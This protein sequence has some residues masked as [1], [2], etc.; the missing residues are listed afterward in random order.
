M[1]LSFLYLL[2]ATNLIVGQVPPIANDDIATTIQNTPLNSSAPGLLENDTHGAGDVIIIT[3]FLINGTTLLPD[4]LL[5]L[6]KEIL[7]FLKM[8]AIL[9]LPLEIIL[10]KFL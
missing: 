4:K 3:E 10:G 9:L 5:I 7:Q 6:L 1:P 8:V 2:F